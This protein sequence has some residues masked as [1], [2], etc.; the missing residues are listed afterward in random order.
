VA[1]RIR[2]ALAGAD[3]GRI[4]DRFGKQAFAMKNAARRRHFEMQEK[5]FRLS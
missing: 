1:R 5:V 4:N 2:G 3:D